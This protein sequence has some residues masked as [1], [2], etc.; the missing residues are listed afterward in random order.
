MEKANGEISN[1]TFGIRLIDAFVNI[2]LY[3][4]FITE[5]G[6]ATVNLGN[7]IFTCELCR[8]A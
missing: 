5:L 2:L 8:D 4:K 7:D 1:I 3:I 6:C